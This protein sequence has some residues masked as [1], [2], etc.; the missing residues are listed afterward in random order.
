[1]ARKILYTILV[2]YLIQSCQNSN[3][4]EELMN[5]KWYS[6][7]IDCIEFKDN[8]SYIL[9]HREI[10]IR[11]VPY[12]FTGDN[13]FKLIDTLTGDQ[14][15]YYFEVKDSILMFCN[16]KNTMPQSEKIDTFFYHMN[17]NY[18]YW[19][20]REL[21][22]YGKIISEKEPLPYIKFEF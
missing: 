14:V 9:Y 19:Q 5:K 10:K 3:Q 16:I 1:M 22:F 12:E 8:Q 4:E 2:A 20:R 6:S 17:S 13:K 21:Y 15:E 18:E 11:E 7:K